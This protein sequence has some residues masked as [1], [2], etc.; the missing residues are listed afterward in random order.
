MRNQTANH[1]MVQKELITGTS[2]SARQDAKLL[3]N[4]P[5]L[6]LREIWSSTAL[7]EFGL[8]K[9]DIRQLP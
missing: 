6:N 2:N 7:F 8:A 9:S 4:M 1:G 3:L 5:V